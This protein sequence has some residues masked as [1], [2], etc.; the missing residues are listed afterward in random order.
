MSKIKDLTGKKF[1]YLTV[2]KLDEIK[3][4]M[5]KWICACDCGNI[6]SVYGSNLT[7]GLT[8]SCGCK[9]H[10]LVKKANRINLIGQK[11]GR[12][13][14]I[15]FHETESGD[16]FFNCKCDCGKDVV[17]RGQDLKRGSTKSCGCLKK[18]FVPSNKTHGM[19]KTRLFKIWSGMRQRCNNKNNPKYKVYGGRGITVCDEWNDFSNFMNWSYKNGYND[20][21]TIDRID[22]NGNYCPS[23]CRWSTLKEQANNTRSTVF[24]TYKGEKKPAS[25]WSK[26]TGIPQ[27][28]LTKRKRNGWSDEECI[29][30]PVDIIRLR[31]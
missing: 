13:T 3:N 28:T 10:E 25:E 19:S 16:T 15:S 11:F 14:V 18:E 5:S 20:T 12:L 2:L 24:L 6:K 22:P 7:R 9:K 31:K 23:N 30:T 8:K 1:G 21:L 27:D 4:G 17:V 29:K 26:I